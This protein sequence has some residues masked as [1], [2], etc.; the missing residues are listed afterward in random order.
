MPS[1]HLNFATEGIGQTTRLFLCPNTNIGDD[2]A[3]A[4]SFSAFAMT[5]VQ[6]LSNALESV[7]VQDENY[8]SNAPYAQ[9][10][11]KVSRSI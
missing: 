5:D 7:S 6:Y 8:D 4:H 1:F 2:V 3:T 11:A 9:H 10:K